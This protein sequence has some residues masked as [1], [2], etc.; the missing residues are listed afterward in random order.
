M[1]LVAEPVVN[2]IAWAG[3]PK[4]ESYIPNLIIKVLDFLVK[5]TIS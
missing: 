3:T 5:Q 4:R 1:F 2:L